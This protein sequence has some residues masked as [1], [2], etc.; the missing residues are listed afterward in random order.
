[1]TISI[2]KAK[3]YL[4]SLKSLD[5]YDD[6]KSKFI[7]TNKLPPRVPR[8]SDFT[9]DAVEKRREVLRKQNC[10][11]ESVCQDLKAVP[12]DSL[13]GSIEN[14]IG[15]AQIPVGV[16]GPLRVNGLFAHDD[17]YVPMATTEGALVASYQR[18]AYVI[19]KNGGANTMC[20]TESVTRAPAFRFKTIV[21]AGMFLE[22]ISNQFPKCQDL[23]K[24]KTRHGVLI[25]L[26][27]TLNSRTVFL[28][29]EY[30]TADASGQ[31]MVTITTDHV[32]HWIE[33]N[34]PVTIKNWYIEGN[35]SGD[36]KATML[37]FLGN[38]GKKV[39][40]EVTISKKD[41]QRILHNSVDGMI[42]YYRTSILGGMQSGSIGVN[43][44]FANALTALFM[45][46]GQD[47]ACVSEASIGITNLE[48]TEDG[49]LYVSVS[50]PNLIV[51][52]VGGG[53]FMPTAQDCLKM[54]DCQ[55]PGKARKFAEICA[56]TVLAGEIS[57]IAALASGDFTQAHTTFRRKHV[58]K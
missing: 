58:E 44:H 42:D 10:F 53:T 51:G 57:I 17:F 37:S 3:Q 31:N 30:K 18:G 38:R 39:V 55:G 36:K 16:I 22:W 23:V 7:N 40:S 4:E 6:F 11:P 54:L 29:F 25:D 56:A 20:L 28:T 12:P 1:M 5:D 27:F 24:E 26:K 9:Q 14:F 41:V 8:G 19:S 48:K 33:K 49:D 52:T 32:C 2:V 13:H 43:G 47:V 35:Q 50:L 21:E 46:C 15:F 34:S 45:C